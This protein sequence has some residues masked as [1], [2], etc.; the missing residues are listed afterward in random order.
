[1]NELT[2]SDRVDRP[3]FMK[4]DLT[5]Q[6]SG[7]VRQSDKVNLG[8]GDKICQ[9]NNCIHSITISHFIFLFSVT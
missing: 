8:A 4:V 1:M 3:V 9:G 7:H 5:Y 2:R 6:R